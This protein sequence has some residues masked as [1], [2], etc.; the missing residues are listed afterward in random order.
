[1]VYCVCI[2]E[3]P[4]WGDSNENTQHTFILKKTEK[5]IYPC[6][7][8]SASLARTTLSRIYIHGSKGVRAIEALL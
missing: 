5:K 8:T 6:Y 1:M 2:L 3:S 4:Q 7:A